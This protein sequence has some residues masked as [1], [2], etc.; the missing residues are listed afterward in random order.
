MLP[1]WNESPF[2]RII[3]P[4]IFGIICYLLFPSFHFVYVIIFLCVISICFVIFGAIKDFYKL[5]YAFVKGILIHILLVC[6]GYSICVFQHHATSK[7]WYKY[8]SQNFPYALVKIKEAPEPKEKTL[9]AEVDV[10]KLCDSVLST[11]TL[12]SA[13]VYFQRHEKNNTL[14]QGDFV[15][16]KNK[17]KDISSSGN[18]G[19]FNYAA[20]CAT[21]NI[22]QTAFIKPDEWQKSNQHEEDYNSFFAR[23]NEHTRSILKKYLPDS[24]THGVA[25]ALLLGYRQDISDDTWQAF[26]NSGI[27]HIIAISGMHMAMVYGTIRWLLLLI[28]SF[29]KRK[30]LALSF[31]ILFMWLFACITGLPASVCRAAIM[32]TFIAWGEMQDQKS[33][34]LNMLAASAFCML[35]F[36]PML[37][38]DVGFQLSY[39]AVISLILFYGPIYNLYYVANTYFDLIWKLTAVT[40][41][42]QILTFP[43]CIYYFHQFPLLFLFTNLIAVPLTTIILYAEIVLVLLHFITPMAILLGKIVSYLLSFVN[44]TVGWFG[45]LTFAVWS[46]I[47]I[48][49][50]QMML[51]FVIIAFVAFWLFSKKAG[52]LLIALSAMMLFCIILLI[53]QY[54]VFHQQKILVYNIPNQK[55]IEF[56][57]GSKYYNSDKDSI[58][59]KA[60]NETYT[61]KPAHIFFGVK[62]QKEPISAFSSI[63]PV[64]LFFFKNKKIMRIENTN[65]HSDSSI[66]LDLLI[67]SKKCNMDSAWLSRNLKPKHII[68]DGSIPFWKIESIKKQL[69]GLSVPIHVV[70]EQGAFVLDVLK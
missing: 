4:F 39:L 3:M 52:Q 51:L 53:K 56:I 14:R 59:K 20:Y 9:K 26:S 58:L 27:V 62:E 50:V 18:P 36:N 49:A 28:P 46:E 67:L 57:S 34:S 5:K 65:F 55:N 11:N 12:G 37:L 23:I 66:Y 10:I 25:E 61:L 40:L 1:F 22:F 8:H 32:F 19:S 13:I 68:L 54:V 69:A 44:S 7:Y 30:K 29:R 15:L 45:Q 42:A 6:F 60:K 33:N 17:F 43:V 31:A 48:S 35:C 41:A 63:G 16:V 21:K 70:S 38:Q 24:S 64:E 47:H 2:V